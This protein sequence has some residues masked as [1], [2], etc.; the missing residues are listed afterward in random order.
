METDYVVSVTATE[1][2]SPPSEEIT[3]RIDLQG[4]YN[5][6]VFCKCTCVQLFIISHKNVDYSI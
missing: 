5:I 1:C 3:V 2:G 4:I 6:H